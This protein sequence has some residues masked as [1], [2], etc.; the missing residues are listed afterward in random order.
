M[1]LHIFKAEYI[2]LSTI[3]G[4]FYGYAYYKTGKI[5]CSVIVHFGLNLCHV[6]LFTYPA[7]KTL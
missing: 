6:L 3:C 1:G 4:F 5:L 2:A 7:L